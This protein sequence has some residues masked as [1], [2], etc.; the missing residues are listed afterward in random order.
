M[1]KIKD[2]CNVVLEKNIFNVEIKSTMRLDEFCTIQSST[3]SQA[4]Y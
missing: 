1:C 4:K 3:I 2:E